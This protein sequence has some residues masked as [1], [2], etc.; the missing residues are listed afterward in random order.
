MTWRFHEGDV[1]ETLRAYPDNHF[2]GGLTDP[3]YGLS[4]APTPEEMRAILL[5]WLFGQP[6]RPRK[7]GF[8]GK[9]WDAFVPGPEV[10]REL[11]RVLKPGAHI[12]VFA[13]TRTMDLMGL[14]LRLA[15]FEVR[16]A[17][18]WLYGSGFPK[19]L[20]MDK[21]IDSYLGAAGDREVVGTTRTNVGMQGGNFTA[22]SASGEVAITKAATPEAQRF[23]GYGAALKPGFEPALLAMKPMSGTYAENALTH[24][25]AGLNIDGARIAGAIDPN[26]W[27]GEQHSPGLGYNGA[28]GGRGFRTQAHDAG[29][30]PSNVAIDETVAAELGDRAPYFYTAK[31]NRAERDAG[32]DAEP[33]QT[34]H[35]VNPGGLEHDPKWAPR[36]VK[37]AH[38]CVK[39]IALTRQLATL[40]LPPKREHDVRRLVVPFCGSGSEAI[41]GLLAGWDDITGIE[42]DPEHCRVADARMRHHEH[43]IRP[44]PK[45]DVE[46]RPA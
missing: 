2:D 43:E 19:S 30:Y 39:P 46:N 40:L 3:P 29:R 37:N 17:T 38:P 16:D 21:A 36:E 20:A 13:G 27:G 5:A 9:S 26:K 6:Y 45:R 8:M 4:D 1:I 11:Y 32:L 7:K 33:D 12:Y 22:G 25:I 14:S 34:M 41:G 44:L 15:G 42:L 18:A 28:E 31:A 24:A 23:E 10:W 35:R